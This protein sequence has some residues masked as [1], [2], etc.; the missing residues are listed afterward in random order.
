MKKEKTILGGR[1]MKRVLALLLAL[2]MMLSFAACSGKKNDETQ[3]ESEAT[4]AVDGIVEMDETE[5]EEQTEEESQTEED[6]TVINT[7]KPSKKPVKVPANG[8]TSSIGNGSQPVKP[9]PEYHAVEPGQHIYKITVE[10][11]SRGKLVTVDGTVYNLRKANGKGSENGELGQAELIKRIQDEKKNDLLGQLYKADPTIAVDLGLIAMEGG[12]VLSYTYNVEGQYFYINDKESWQQNFGFNPLYD[13][14]A[15]F[16]VMYYD[17]MRLEFKYDNDYENQPWMVQLWKGQY[18]Y[19]FI[20]GEIGLYTKYEN[21]PDFSDSNLRHYDCATKNMVPMQQTLWRRDAEGNYRPLF[22]TTYGRH[23]WS[24]GFV[25]GALRSFAERDELIME[26]F[27]DFSDYPGM[28]KLVGDEFRKKNNRTG[29]F[30]E[31]PA[32]EKMNILRG[33]SF[34]VEGDKLYFVWK[35]Y[36]DSKVPPKAPVVSTAPQTSEPSSTK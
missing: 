4:E 12:N 26:G 13:F 9:D 22:Q 18:G 36:E 10:K 31:V 11:T 28:A 33:D 14:G 8:P 15:T 25:P 30:T 1:K 27:I 34:K 7:Q 35:D 23:W 19:V 2:A 32:G 29:K 20:G 5:A 21:D 17:T 16:I 3:P 24:T 6:G